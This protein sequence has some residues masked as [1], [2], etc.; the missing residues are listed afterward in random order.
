MTQDHKEK[1]R[2]LF[3]QGYN[4]SQ[5]V[6]C[7]FADEY[8][9]P[10]ETALK[11]S[12]SFGGGIGR[13]RETCGAFCGAAMVLGMETGQTDAAK[14]EQKQQNYHTVQKAAEMFRE[15]NGST[16]CAELLQ[17]R[18]DA[19]ITDQPDPRTA[20]YYRQRP[21]LRMVESAVEIVES[22]KFKHDNVV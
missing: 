7:A 5:A 3:I 14:P 17:L 15:K 9:I 4:C 19:V 2:S 8:G 11:L 20:E 10:Q 18:K 1:A 16:K 21:C 22:M 13:M 12:A 6:F